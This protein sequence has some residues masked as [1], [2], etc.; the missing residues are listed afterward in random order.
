M[1]GMVKTKWTVEVATVSVGTEVCDSGV[2]E[3][4]GADSP[5]MVG[6]GVKTEASKVPNRSCGFPVPGMSL[7]IW[8]KICLLTGGTSNSRGSWL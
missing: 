4:A 5:F 1:T 2:A 6:T 7:M 3:R 8:L